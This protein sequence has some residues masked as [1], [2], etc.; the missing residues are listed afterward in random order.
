MF[1]FHL[2]AGAVFATG[3]FTGCLVS[4]VALIAIAF[5]ASKQKK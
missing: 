4:V 3:V 2:S 1:T 5:I